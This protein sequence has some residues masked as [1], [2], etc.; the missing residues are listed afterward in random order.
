MST[1]TKKMFVS[2]FAA[3]VALASFGWSAWASYF[4]DYSATG[5]GAQATAQFNAA[6][7]EVIQT[8]WSMVYTYLKIALSFI[9]ANA[10]GIIIISL[11]LGLIAFIAY[12]RRMKK[13]QAKL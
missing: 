5:S 8:G 3:M 11:L 7:W 13:V 12:K 6:G 9:Q 1:K 4:T 10:I 2:A